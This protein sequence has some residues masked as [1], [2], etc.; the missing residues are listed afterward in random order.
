MWRAE[1][2][3]L[4]HIIQGLCPLKVILW[5][6]CIT[7]YLGF[8]FN[9]QVVLHS[10]TDRW[11]RTDY[12]SRD[13][14]KQFTFVIRKENPTS[15]FMALSPNQGCSSPVRYKGVAF[16]YESKD[17]LHLKK[18]QRTR[19]GTHLF[20]LIGISASLLHDFLPL[21]P[22]SPSVGHGH[23]EHPWI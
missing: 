14:D 23:E 8:V 18:K 10:F 11:L 21:R 22:V 12:L 6:F 20:N 15:L 16:S 4:W 19:S 7:E 13:P 2:S 1:V 5:F 3:M 9:C 17:L